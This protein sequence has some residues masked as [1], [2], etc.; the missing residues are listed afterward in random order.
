[1]AIVVIQ[2]PHVQSLFTPGQE[3]LHHPADNNTQIKFVDK[4]F[5]HP[6]FTWPDHPFDIALIKLNDHFDFNDHVA[7]VLLNN[8][9]IPS[10]VY[11]QATGWGHL[12]EDSSVNSG[13][14]QKVCYSFE[15]I[16]IWFGVLKRY[17]LYFFRSLFQLYRMKRA[18]CPTQMIWLRSR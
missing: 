13:H 10:G 7:L 9:V 18:G 11:C 15:R 3:N 6:N 2:H 8:E 12:D 17:L 1:M 14:L 5:V 16:S 4:G